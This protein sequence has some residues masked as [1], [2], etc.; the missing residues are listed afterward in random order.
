[1]L[2]IKGCHFKDNNAPIIEPS[3]YGI[4]GEAIMIFS[5]SIVNFQS[6]V[7]LFT[8]IDFFEMS[9]CEISNIKSEFI[10]NRLM[11]TGT[12]TYICKI[13]N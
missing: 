1:M 12:V 10:Y 13:N 6:R 8:N 9:D 5:S 7:A 3:Y 2:F 4:N 11:K